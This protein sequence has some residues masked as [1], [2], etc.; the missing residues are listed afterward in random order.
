MQLLNPTFQHPLPFICNS[1]VVGIISHL[2][3]IDFVSRNSYTIITCTYIHMYTKPTHNLGNKPRPVGE[4]VAAANAT[5][6]FRR[7]PTCFCAT[8]CP[9]FFG[10]CV[11]CH[12]WLRLFVSLCHFL[13]PLNHLLIFPILRQRMI[14]LCLISYLLLV[15]RP[16]PV[17]YI[18]HRCL[19]SQCLCVDLNLQLY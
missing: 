5:S 14:L 6:A 18:R 13:P 16:L 10:A 8:L 12:R 17:V 9:R 11:W 19:L 15:T 4:E 1:I 3:K 7:F 2:E